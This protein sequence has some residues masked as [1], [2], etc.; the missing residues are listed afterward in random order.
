MRGVVAGPGIWEGG[1]GSG[2]PVGQLLQ[3]SRNRKQATTSQGQVTRALRMD[4]GK[5]GDA[6]SQGE[7]WP[8]P[9]VRNSEKESPF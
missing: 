7:C 2:R 1:G 6:E 8:L 5:G 4:S 9:C 3:T